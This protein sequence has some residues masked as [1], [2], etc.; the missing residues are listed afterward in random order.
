MATAVRTLSARPPGR[1]LRQELLRLLGEQ[2]GMLYTQKEA[3]RKSVP[4]GMFGVIDD[5]E[6]SL[7]D[8]ELEIGVSVLEL[9][10][11][12]VQRIEAALRRM[13]AGGYGN[14]S[15]C[16]SRISPARLRALPFADR[17][18]GCQ[19]QRDIAAFAMRRQAGTD[20]GRSQRPVPGL[21]DQHPP[22][23]TRRESRRPAR[24]DRPTSSGRLAARSPD[25]LRVDS[26]AP[27]N[28]IRNRSGAALSIR[29]RPR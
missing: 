12:T 4:A 9:T 19:Q 6:H 3:L 23:R 27:P 18:R 15:D 20:E 7:D 26:S 5:E 8:E 11:Q 16:R 29:C 25:A 24:C 21:K 1:A 13:D 14:C 17:C 2:D 10:S 28:R 22:E